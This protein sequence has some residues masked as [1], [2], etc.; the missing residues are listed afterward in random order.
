MEFLTFILET[1]TLKL[2]F[3]TL[4]WNIAEQN[5]NVAPKNLIIG[6][7]MLI[8]MIG[9]YKNPRNIYLRYYNSPLLSNLRTGLGIDQIDKH[10]KKIS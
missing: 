10:T 6:F 5:P 1:P 8:L 4:S 7:F 2:A 9:H 3:P